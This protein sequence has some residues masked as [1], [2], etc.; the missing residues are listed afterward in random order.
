MPSDGAIVFK[1]K[2]DNSDVQKDLDRVKRDIEKSQK[3]IA[4]S[5]SAKLPLLKD[6]EQLKIK[7]Q[8]ARQELAFIKEEQAT[9][10]AAMQE[11]A[12]LPD[13]MAAN[14]ALPAINAAVE[15]QKRKVD[16]LEKEWAQVNSKI[17]QYNQKIAQ[18]QGKLTEQ[19]ARAGELSKQ[20]A[21]GGHGMAAAMTKAQ[22][23]AQKFQMRLGR[24]LKQVFV[25]GLISKALYGV[26]R[27]L[28][29]ALKSNKEFTA[30]LAKL[31]GALLTAFQ[32]LYEMLL[33]ALMALMR[34]ATSVITAVARVASLLGGKSMSQYAKSAEALYDEANAIEETGEAAKKA[35]KSLAG[36]DEINQLDNNSAASDSSSAGTSGPDFSSF[37]TSAIKQEVD[38]LVV[39]LSSALLLIGMVLALSGANIP[40]G[41][42]L[43][44]AGAIGLASEVATNW[45]TVRQIIS[46]QTEMILAISAILFIVGL[47]LALSGA[48][49]PLGIGLMVAGA[50]GLATPI[51]TDWGSVRKVL[52]E[53]VA[54]V[55]G[56]S[57]LLLVIG[58]ILCFCG[59]L[60]LG[61]GL[62]VV[63]ASGVVAEAAVE[64]N[65][66]KGPIVA[67][68]ASLLAILSGASV[69]LGVLLL[70]SGVGIG[71]GLALI[72]EGIA[73]SV[74]AWKLN[75]NPVTRFVKGIANT[76]IGFVN[77]IIEAIN[78]L[79]H[80]KFSGLT[81][82]G[83][84]IIPKIDTKL[85]DIPKI[86]L[87]AQGAVLPPNKPFMAMVGD[88]RHGTN[89]EA[90]LSTIQE[91]VAEV[92]AD[93]EASNLAGHEATVE[94]L[95]Q[96]LSAVLSI[97]VGDT[98]I[99]QAANRFNR[100]MAVTTGDV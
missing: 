4:E 86:P 33:P 24:I 85:L 70:F 59:V 49:I 58:I 32:P 52:E 74:A 3:S 22:A 95:R 45:E 37:D 99:G 14:D 26:I 92:M 65:S 51:A 77:M 21:A 75:D 94:V 57:A 93:Y 20:L 98:V 68:L 73:G 69:V 8:E 41:I 17:T 100:R 83:V 18:A 81:I 35:Q 23:S 80:I 19:Q 88:Q 7:L 30:E 91:A 76:I 43:M 50:A 89:I 42:G 64:W 66:I 63:G 9:A 87:L 28:G 62:I 46:E 40:L 67:T 47:I 11:G 82:A 10:Q 54:L 90:P 55:T 25:F 79:F 29:A 71:L 6:A 56:I 78:S 96:L 53:Q 39:Y 44:A 16:G 31:K 36:F 38:E 13:Y 5:E 72:A 48:A 15:E 1:T 97:E 34:I 60:P 12:S 61:I 2:I 27:Y 84:Q